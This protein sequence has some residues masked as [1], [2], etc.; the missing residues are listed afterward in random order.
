MRSS[1]EKARLSWRH[2]K[3]LRAY[4]IVTA[5]ALLVPVGFISWH[6]ANPPQGEVRK[7][8]AIVSLAP[9][10]DRLPVS[11]AL[12]HEGAADQLVI[13]WEQSR[14]DGTDPLFTTDQLEY[15]LCTSTTAHDVTCLRP[16]PSTTLGEVLAIN[17]LA[18]QGDW[19]T[20]T[21]VTSRYHAYRTQ[22]IMDRCLTP[23]LDVELIYSEPDLNA[24]EWIWRV[25]YEN[26]AMVKALVETSTE[27]G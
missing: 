7:A 20:V 15:R 2:G 22:F 27:C 14:Y 1:P 12:F 3:A 24:L 13:S 9:Y 10:F 18:S 4:A 17:R 25:A 19:S 8:D 11:Y 6:A 26:A 5:V 23:G 21:V 16:E